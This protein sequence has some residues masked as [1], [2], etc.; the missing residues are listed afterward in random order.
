MNSRITLLFL[1]LPF[2]AMFLLSPQCLAQEVTVP[3][4]G[5]VALDKNKPPLFVSYERPDDRAWDGRTYVIGVL[6]RLTNNSNCVISLTAPPGYPREVPPTSG[7]KDGKMVRLPDVRI[8]SI[9]SGEKVELYYLTKYPGDESLYLDRDFHVRDT[10]YLNNG[11]YILFS[12]PMK[13]FKLHGRVLVPF[14]Y[15]WD[16]AIA[17]FVVEGKRRKQAYEA[18]KHYLIFDHERLFP[19]IS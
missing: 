1:L 4:G 8:G 6:L 5:C 18:V 9:K 15:D 13:N 2:V 14:H 19:Q 16:S 12:V 17:P 10:I 7:I 11:D 3:Q